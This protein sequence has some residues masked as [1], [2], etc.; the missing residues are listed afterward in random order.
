MLAWQNGLDWNG[1]SRQNS[2]FAVVFS[3]QRRD[4]TQKIYITFQS[5]PRTC[6]SLQIVPETWSGSLL[7][8]WA[9][10]C[11]KQQLTT[12]RKSKAIFAPGKVRNLPGAAI[13]SRDGL[14]ERRL[15]PVLF[16]PLFCSFSSYFLAINTVA[17]YLKVVLVRNPFS[18]RVPKHEKLAVRY[19]RKLFSPQSIF[20]SPISRY[21]KYRRC[22]FIRKAPII[23]IQCT[24]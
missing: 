2:I 7:V 4:D 6:K 13:R 15:G 5:G 14:G 20:S 17:G 9:A 8:L 18:L 1:A 24:C 10:M 11:F 22:V 23:L 3:P 21:L 19:Q 16:F 12:T